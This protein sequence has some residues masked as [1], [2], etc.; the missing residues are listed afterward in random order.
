MPIVLTCAC[1]RRLQIRDEYAGQEGK[2]PACGRTFDIPTPC[3]DETAP[4]SLEPVRRPEPDTEIPEVEPVPQVDPVRDPQRRQQDRDEMPRRSAQQARAQAQPRQVETPVG[5]PQQDDGTLVPNHG[6][7]ALPHDV[8]FFAPPPPEIG[9]LVTAYSTLRQ[10]IQPRPAGARVAI[11]GGVAL[12]TASVVMMI[13]AA[14]QPRE[15]VFYV[16]WPAVAGGLA[17]LIAVLTTRFRHRC[18]YVGREGL[19]RFQ[20]AGDRDRVT[21]PEFFLFRD[22]AEVRTGQTRR[23]VNGVYQGTDYTF[24]WSDVAGRTR[25]VIRGTYKAEQGNP[26]STDPYH[27]GRSAEIAFTM[28]LL[29]DVFSRLDMGG[30]VR[31]NV[32][33]GRW[34]RLGPGYMIIQTG[35]AEEQWDAQEINGVQIHQ[36]VVYIRRRDAKEGWFSSKGVFKFDFAALANAQLFIYLVEKVVGVPIG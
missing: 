1:G 14:A 23:Y 3:D 7:E 16:F 27:F 30:D 5:V 31:F 11:A 22:A 26:R 34:I 25:H 29:P 17:A 18:T 12:I 10:K 4:F 32:S 9:P 36:G 35:G 15:K 6:S 20:C 13:V 2:C 33:G 24:T 28:S 8:D 21:M 19:A